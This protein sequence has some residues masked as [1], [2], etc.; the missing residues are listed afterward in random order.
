MTILGKLFSSE[1]DTR[2]RDQVAGRR[3]GGELPGF[4]S[5]TEAID[6]A[7]FGGFFI[8]HIRLHLTIIPIGPTQHVW[9]DLA[10]WG[11]SKFM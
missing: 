7:T 2:S 6:V 8:L 11:K 10:I 4:H 3:G 9:V 1:Q 5:S